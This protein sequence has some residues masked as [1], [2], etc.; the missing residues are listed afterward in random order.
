M[1]GQFVLIKANG[2]V[3]IKLRETPLTLQETQKA[4]GGPVQE[5]PLKAGFK[6][7]GEPAQMFVHEE[8]KLRGFRVNRVAT[9]LIRDFDPIWG[10][11]VLV[12]DVVMLTGNA[13]W[14]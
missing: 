10:S 7:N 3:N 12:G 2:Q 11:D 5:V 1:S 6:W 8:G 9:Q 4:V 13:R 14:K